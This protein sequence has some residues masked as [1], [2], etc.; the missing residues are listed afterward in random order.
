MC[1]FG[2]P[3]ALVTNNGKQ[4]DSKKFR[5]FLSGL[6]IALKFSLVAHPKKNKQAELMNK[7]IIQALEKNLDE[8]KGLQANKLPEM[9][10]A[11]KTSHKNSTG[12]M[13]FQ[14]AFGTEAVILMEIRLPSFRVSHFEQEINDEHLYI[15]VD[16]IEE[17]RDEGLMKDESYKRKVAKYYKRIIKNKQF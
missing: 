3:K 12:K 16:L 2:V 1:K 14:L 9:L 17:V 7:I 13:P 10:W 5:T 8:A 15:N 4:F 11:Y 6:S